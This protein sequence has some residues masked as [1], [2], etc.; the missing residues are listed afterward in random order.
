MSPASCARST[1]MP[2][3]VSNRRRA[4]PCRSSMS[5]RS[6][7]C[8]S[9]DPGF[10]PAAGARPR[11]RPHRRIAAPGRQL[12][13]VERQRRHGAVARR[14]CHRLPA[15]RQ[16]ARESGAGLRADRGARL[17][18]RLCPATAHRCEQPAGDGLCALCAGAGQGRRTARPALFQ[19]HPADR[20]CRP[21]WRRRSLP[22]RSPPMATRRAPLP[23][24]RRRS[25]PPPKRPPG[26]RY[27]DYGSDLRDSAGLLAF[28]GDNP[29]RSRG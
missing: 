6:P 11:D 15:A 4:A 22:R 8:G 5:M 29:A 26:L 16:G 28:A 19:R 18:A 3:A 12:R 14:L 17:A 27:I 7:G 2:M 20:R 10:S 21:S 25:A 24:T 13:G 1:A 9:T 23:P